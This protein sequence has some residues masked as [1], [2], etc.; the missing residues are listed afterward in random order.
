MAQILSFLSL[1]II[2]FCLFYQAA[3]QLGKWGRK[4]IKP[5]RDVKLFSEHFID[6]R[7]FYLKE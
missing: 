6:A 2:V 5:H 7:A 3:Q 4:W 1:M